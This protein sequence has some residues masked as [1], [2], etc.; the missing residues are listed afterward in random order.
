MKITDIALP[1]HPTQL[2][3]PF[4][5]DRPKSGGLHFWRGGT[6]GTVT[7]KGSKEPSPCFFPLFPTLARR[8]MVDDT[9]AAG[10]LCRELRQG[11]S[12]M[13]RAPDGSPFSEWSG[14]WFKINETRAA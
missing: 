14:C 12:A 11:G 1:L 10:R 3:S 13:V 4:I 8:V 5:T 6:W 9:P 2:T 7:P